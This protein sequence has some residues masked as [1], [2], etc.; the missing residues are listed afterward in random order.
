M[1]ASKKKIL[2]LLLIAILLVSVISVGCTP[3]RRPEPTPAPGAPGAPG[4][5]GDPD[6]QAPPG[7]PNQPGDPRTGPQANANQRAERLAQLI[8]DE[9]AEVQTATVVFSEQIVYVGLDLEQEVSQS[10][11]RDIERRVAEM[12][13]EEEPNVDRV[14]VSMDPETFRRLQGVAREIEGG[15]P[16]TGFLTEIEEW[17]RRITPT[18]R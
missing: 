13:M 5:P 3:Q 17:F 11:A 1:F 2:V 14:Y 15:R 7:D 9:F 16:V 6:F 10:R 18:T 4:V 12:V 8:A